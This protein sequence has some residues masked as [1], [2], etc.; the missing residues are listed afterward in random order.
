LE[1]CR[2]AAR[3]EPLAAEAVDRWE[4]W[5]R[6]SRTGSKRE[7]RFRRRVYERARDDAMVALLMHAQSTYR[8]ASGRKDRRTGESLGPD[9][10][11]TRLGVLLRQHVGQR[12][13]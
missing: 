1:F 5:L 4:G 6:S 12:R 2:R 8:R 7:R 11:P 10:A 13:R 3:D 9:P